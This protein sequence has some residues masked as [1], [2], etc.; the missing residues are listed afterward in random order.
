MKIIAHRANLNGPDLN[1][2]NRISSISNCIDSG[3]EVEIDVRLVNGKLYLGH[4]NPDQ[5]IT[6][7]ELDQIKNKLWIH[8]KNLDAFTFFNKINEKFNYFWHETDSYTLTSQGYIWTYPGK[9]LSSRCIC[10]MPELKQPIKE[11]S[12]LK[13]N[14]IAGICTDYPN[15]IK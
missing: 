12:F 10:V 5:I 1:V 14:E 7:R 4:D 8:C 6:K 2:E 11:M 15:L 9:T 13:N 3:F